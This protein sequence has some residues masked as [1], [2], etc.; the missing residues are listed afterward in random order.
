ML[1]SMKAGQLHFAPGAAR[2]HVGQHA[3]QV[4]HAGRQRLHFAQPLVHG[5]QPVGHQF[6]GLAQA[7]L[8]RGMELFV[9]GPAH[10]IKLGAVFRL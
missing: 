7:L 3:L 9:H 1:S 6:E 10:F 4:T 5:F 8:K 2:L